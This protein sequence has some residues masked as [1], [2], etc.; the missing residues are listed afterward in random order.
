MAG[1]KL[2]TLA[3]LAEFLGVPVATGGIGAKGRRVT[4][5]AGIVRYR[6]V[7][8]EAWLHSQAD[9]RMAG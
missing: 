6:R 1:E 5:S 3:D 7:E 4:G 2:M 9:I 8:V